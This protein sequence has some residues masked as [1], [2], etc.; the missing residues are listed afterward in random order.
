MT[1]APDDSFIPTWQEYML[2]CMEKSHTSHKQH[3]PAK[4]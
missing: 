3:N 4:D 1:A 2:N